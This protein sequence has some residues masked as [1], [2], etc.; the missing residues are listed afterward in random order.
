VAGQIHQR[1]MVI[2]FS[3]MLENSL[4]PEK[5]QSLFAAIQHLKYNKHEVIIFNVNDK[6]KELDFNFDNRP[7]HFIDM[8]SGEQIR[9]HPNKIR[10]AYQASLK[11][12]RHQLE[13]KC[14]QYT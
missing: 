1:S 8:E 10:D 5:M 13:L 3:D 11:Q 4:N 9:V 2:L 12:N 7:H 6:Q 14:A